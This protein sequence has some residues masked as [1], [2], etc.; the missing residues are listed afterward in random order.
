MTRRGR[1]ICAKNE[2]VLIEPIP[3][4]M[5]AL[6]C[7]RRNAL[8]CLLVAFAILPV[9]CS[10]PV[11]TDQSSQNLPVVRISRGSFP[12]ERFEN[13]KARLEAS[14]KSLVPAIRGLQGCLHYWAGIDTTSNTMVN[15]SVWKSLEDAKQMETLQPMKTLAAE[16]IQL[17]VTF[18]RPVL[19]YETL[20]QM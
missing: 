7:S 4:V 18:E 17:G 19:N 15:V 20:W 10:K 14:Q 5:F 6:M 8:E 9:G 16:F 11:S 3:S 1:H 12:P 2:T 13:V